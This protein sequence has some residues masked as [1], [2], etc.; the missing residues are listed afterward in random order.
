MI[1]AFSSLYTL[2]TRN[3][4][5]DG[6]ITPMARR[7]ARIEQEIGTVIHG[8]SPDPVLGPRGTFRVEFY[9]RGRYVLAEEAPDYGEA[10]RKAKD[11]LLGS[12]GDEARLFLSGDLVNVAHLERARVRDGSMKYH[13][14]FAPGGEKPR[15][16][17]R[18]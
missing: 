6:I 16:R 7:D 17:A 2:V 12:S 1:H 13:V 18:P 4:F 14:R 3:P 9:E 5:K 15:K 10:L 11:G 8:G